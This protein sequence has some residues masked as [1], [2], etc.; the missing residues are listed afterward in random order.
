MRGG[1]NLMSYRGKKSRN[2]SP[3][4]NYIFS[5]KLGSGKYG[6]VYLAISKKSQEKFA[7]KVIKLKSVEDT[8]D[9]VNELD[10]LQKLDN[11]NLIKY[12]EFYRDSE[13]LYF[14]TQLCEGGELF[15]FIINNHP[16]PELIAKTI[17]Y[18][19][20]QGVKYMHE[21]GVMHRDLK[22][23]NIL[24]VR[25]DDVTDIRI[26]DFGLSIETDKN[27]NKKVGTPYYIAPEVLNRDY[28]SR[29]DI[30]SL[31]IIMYVLLV[32]NAPFNSKDD[33][34]IYRLIKNS[35]NTGV[36]IPYNYQDISNN[37][38]DLYTKLLNYKPRRRITIDEALSHP[39]FN[40]FDPDTMIFK[41][42]TEDEDIVIRDMLIA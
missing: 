42:D 16:F 24:L 1:G 30:W 17:M 15:E 26:V 7:I 9:L 21:R 22:P 5:K 29:C 41:T 34:T 14:V 35:K 12:Y 40:D 6:K 8:D 28:D 27:D 13:K 32:G 3:Y 19:L 23:E 31:G 36:P 20:F 2:I 33:R 25:P 18:Q 10:F 39:W 37:G 4:D 11:P 38:I